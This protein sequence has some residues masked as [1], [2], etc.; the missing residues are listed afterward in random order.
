MQNFIL[1]Y[2]DTFLTKK[3]SKRVY[4]KKIIVVGNRTTQDHFSKVSIYN[5]SGLKKYKRRVYRN[6]RKKFT[7]RLLKSVLRRSV[8]HYCCL[9][10][11]T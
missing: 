5:F 2:F 8:S 3:G 6:D 4:T 9:S 1:L 10:R 7:L 11:N